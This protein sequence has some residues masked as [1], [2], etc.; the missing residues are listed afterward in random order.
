MIGILNANTGA[1]K[2]TF[3]K[4]SEPDNEGNYIGV[5]IDEGTEL[6]KKPCIVR[7]DSVLILLEKQDE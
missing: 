4:L 5:G 2:G 7:A 6:F 3:V 1:F